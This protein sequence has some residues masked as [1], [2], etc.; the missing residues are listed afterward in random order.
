MHTISAEEGDH[1]RALWRN[2]YLPLLGG[3]Q[4][5]ASD[6]ARLWRPIEQTVSTSGRARCRL[7]SGEIA[8]GAGCIRFGFDPYGDKGWGRLASAY[9]HLD[10]PGEE[11]TT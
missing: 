1:L 9:I 4:S 10:C 6:L 5:R 7:C 11:T 8:K 2:G 3:E